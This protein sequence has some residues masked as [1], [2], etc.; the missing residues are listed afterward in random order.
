MKDVGGD[1]R[2]EE[3][4]RRDEGGGRRVERLGWRGEAGGR[5]GLGREEGWGPIIVM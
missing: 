1:I 5:M 4:R 2:E 3:G